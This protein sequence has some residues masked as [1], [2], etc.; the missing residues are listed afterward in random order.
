MTAVVLPF[1]HDRRDGAPRPGLRLADPGS[2]QPMRPA[3]RAHP[4]SIYARRRLAALVF[5]VA[6]AAALLVGGR[7]LLG[8]LGGG[9][10]AAPD[11][12]RPR[13]VVRHVYVVQP[14]DT[15]WSIARALHPTGD[16]RRVVQLLE[17]RTGGAALHVGDRIE[18][19]EGAMA[20]SE[21]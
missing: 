6:A 7:A 16:V 5:V 9:P 2:R 15:L 11:T 10:L 21:R 17:D 18:L 19:P 12:S 4:P 8:V 13:L 3:S 14:G 20:P 1:P